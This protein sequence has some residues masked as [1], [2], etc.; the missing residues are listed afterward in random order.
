MGSP[1]HGGVADRSRAH[2]KCRALGADT[3]AV[4]ENVPAGLS[5]ESFRNVSARISRIL[6]AADTETL[7]VAVAT[8][9]EDLGSWAGADLAFV[10]LV[11]GADRVT[12]DWNWVRAGFDVLGPAIGAPLSE[13]VGSALEFVKIGHT[14]A[15]DDLDNVELSPAERRFATHNDLRA[16][17][18]APV[19][20][21]GVFLGIFGLQTIGRP[22]AWEP[23][24]VDR[25]ELVAAVLVQTV[26]RTQQRGAVEQANARARCI[27]RLVPS[28]LV[29]L[30]HSNHVTWVSPS[31]TTTTGRR[32]D[33]VLGLPIT[34]LFIAEDQGLLAALG[35]PEAISARLLRSDGG[36]RWTELSW[37]AIDEEDSVG[38]LNDEGVLELR[39]IHDRQ[40]QV[41]ELRRDADHDP[42]TG[43]LNLSGLRRGLDTVLL[44]GRTIMTAFC[45]LNGF[46]RYNDTYGHRAGDALLCAVAAGLAQAVRS[47]DLVARVGGDEFV[48]IR[49]DPSGRDRHD[50]Q[51]RLESAVADLT[52]VEG[53]GSVTVAVGV[54]D[55]GPATDAARQRIDADAAMYRHKRRP[56]RT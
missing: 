14:V 33:E 7:G 26:V 48:I 46:K 27:A 32:A 21:A 49:V 45:D 8:V 37:Q 28:P 17:L 15:V 41:D 20:I 47:E 35:A 12:D 11:D 16:V 25:L 1:G 51:A 29:M 39:D 43:A 53:H 44:A 34:R 3:V 42:L 18:M 31:F 19:R 40:L 5:E 6:G 24:L 38:G 10:A 23:V 56:L 54:S 36:W 4:R 30:D 13:T 9:L 2:L 55:P 52:S 22:R 50:L